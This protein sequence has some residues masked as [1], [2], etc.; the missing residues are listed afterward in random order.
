MALSAL[1]T[2]VSRMAGLCCNQYHCLLENAALSWR[3]GVMKS[4]ESCMYDIERDTELY[5]IIIIP[6]EALDTN[7]LP[8]SGTCS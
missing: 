8:Y 6:E 5:Y 4:L 2:R 7:I 3:E 1:N